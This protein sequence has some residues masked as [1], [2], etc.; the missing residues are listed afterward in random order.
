M[1]RSRALTPLLRLGGIA[2]LMFATASQA[3][4]QATL[5]GRVADPDGNPLGGAQVVI[6][7]LP[8]YGANTAQNGTYT[9]VVGAAQV[10]GQSL[11][12]V[13]RML[14]RSPAVRTFVLNAGQQ[15][16]NF[17]LRLDPL[18]LEELVV[19]GVSEA[20]STRKLPFAI[21]RLSAD[22]LQETPGVTALSGLVG[23]VAGLRLVEATGEPGAASAPVRSRLFRLLVPQCNQRIDPGNGKRRS[24]A[25]GHTRRLGAPLAARPGSRL[26]APRGRPLPLPG[27]TESRPGRELHQP[28]QFA[29]ER[30]HDPS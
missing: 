26:L 29:K 5:T 19:T 14:G 6:R 17:T 10:R 16:L 30:G 11:T 28:L 2:A 20:T 8:S 12:L 25:G 13:A 9:I 1:N 21:G 18:R 4:A 24:P 23:K 27:G 22:Q 3:Q 7:E 15:E